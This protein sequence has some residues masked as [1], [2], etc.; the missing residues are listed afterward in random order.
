M[1]SIHCLFLYFVVLCKV[2]SASKHFLG[3][4]GLSEAYNEK[5]MPSCCINTGRLVLKKSVFSCM[6]EYAEYG[7]E[8]QR[9][10]SNGM[11]FACGIWCLADVL[12][13]SPLSEH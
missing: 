10:I 3:L 5:N 8:Q 2:V 12:S 1:S 7:F 6:G 4:H 13:V 11:F 9:L